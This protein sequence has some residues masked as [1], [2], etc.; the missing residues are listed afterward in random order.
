MTLNTKN[1]ITLFLL[2]G[3]IS[4]QKGEQ[5]GVVPTVTAD[6][7]CAAVPGLEQFA[8]ITAR[9]DRM[10][11]SGNL[12][13]ADAFFLK[14][15]I[16][17]LAGKADGVVII[18]GTDTLE[19]MAFVLDHILDVDIPVVLTGAMRSPDT[20]SADG[21]GNIRSSVQC[22]ATEELARAGAVVVMNNDI[23]AARHVRKCHTGDVAAFRSVNGSPLGR[24][25]EGVTEIVSIPKR[26]TVFKIP[27]NSPVPKVALIKAAFDEG[28]DLLK[29]IADSDY[30]GLVIE[31]FGAG[32]VPESW[33]DQ[34]DELV[35][36]M[37]VVLASRTGEGRVF[38]KTYGYK[39]AEIDLISRGLIPAGYY[40]G[41]KARLYLQLMMMAGTE[42]S[43]KS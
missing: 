40:D 36:K 1:Q 34:L 8:D 24:V 25:V 3:T 4:M 9:T 10:V 30:Q 42:I 22:A 43:F 21:P 20:P 15:E 39:G 33:L 16:E 12:G 37:P 2:G 32:H 13:F 27:A 5:D 19:E 29:L 28:D 23:H 18:Q 31:A 17:N 26:N 14:N 41:V 38:E 6:E 7:L 35:G 11:A